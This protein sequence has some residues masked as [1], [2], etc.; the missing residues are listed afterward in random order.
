MSR[1][2][3]CASPFDSKGL[4]SPPGEAHTGEVPSWVILD[5]IMQQ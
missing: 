1:F 4:A 5:V 3:D 2:Q